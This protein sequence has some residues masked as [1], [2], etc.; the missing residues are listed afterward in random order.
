MCGTSLRSVTERDLLASYQKKRARDIR[1]LLP[2]WDPEHSSFIQLT[3]FNETPNQRLPDQLGEAE[4]CHGR[5]A[6]YL[7]SLFGMHEKYLR[8][9]P[10]I[11]YANIT[12]M[13][14]DALIAFYDATGIGELNFTLHVKKS[15]NRD[16][17]YKIEEDFLRMWNAS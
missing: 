5:I 6:G 17:Y 4:D 14:E 12:I 11:M 8:K 15:T 9:H 16:A 1:I 13:D 7:I 10:G 2:D 3:E